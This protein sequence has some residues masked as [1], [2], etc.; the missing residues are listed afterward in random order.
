V[1]VQLLFLIY[2]TPHPVPYHNAALAAIL[3]SHSRQ[4]VVVDVAALEHWNC[5][6]MMVDG[7]SNDKMDPIDSIYVT[8]AKSWQENRILPCSRPVCK[9]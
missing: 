3:P 6:P 8:L 1:A 4:H 9:K 7:I 2:L 5:L